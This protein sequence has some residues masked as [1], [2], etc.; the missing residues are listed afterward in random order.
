MKCL[1]ISQ[2]HTLPIIPECKLKFNKG[3]DKT[4]T[5]TSRVRRIFG[6]S[7]WMNIFPHEGVFNYVNLQSTIYRIIL[8]IQSHSITFSLMSWSRIRTT[9]RIILLRQRGVI[10]NVQNGPKHWNAVWFEKQFHA[11]CVLWIKMHFILFWNVA[12]SVILYPLLAF[13]IIETY[14]N[15]DALTDLIC[16][17][18]LTSRGISYRIS[19]CSL[20]WWTSQ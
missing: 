12:A 8:Y 9:S 2:W 15:S 18:G 7:K 11:N 13:F 6:F 14:V 10:Q 5:T 16:I 20:S 4:I 3:S 19:I 17:S 1:V